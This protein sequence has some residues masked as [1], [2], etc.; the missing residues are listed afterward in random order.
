MIRH[1]ILSLT[2]K[3]REV[4]A[5]VRQ[6]FSNKEIAKAMDVK[7]RTIESHLY[8][9]S[10]KLNAKN[11]LELVLILDGR[12]KSR[13]EP[14]LSFSNTKK[15][16][17]ARIKKLYEQGLSVLQIAERVGIRYESARVHLVNMKL[18]ETSD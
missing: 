4:I 7:C 17:K 2:P 13:I 5:F 11:R 16:L 14:I 10:Y 9:A 3:E 12:L 1:P 18:K 15:L 8:N 6:G